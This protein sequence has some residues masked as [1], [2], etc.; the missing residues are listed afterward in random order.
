MYMTIDPKEASLFFQF[1]YELYDN[2]AFILTSNKGPN[3]W[4]KFLGD[5]TLTTAILDRLLHRSEIISFSEEDDSLRMKYRKT[6]FRN[7]CS[8]LIAENCSKLID[9]NLI[10][11]LN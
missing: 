3:E 4:G 2:V 7:K 6:F 10:S 5:P 9:E 11:F 1:I 8:I